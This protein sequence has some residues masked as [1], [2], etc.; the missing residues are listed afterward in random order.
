M[1]KCIFCKIVKGEIP[2]YKVYED[3]LVLAFLDITPANDGH[4]LIIPKLHRENIF[5]IK[6]EELERVALV[7]KRVAEKCKEA[8]GE[9]ECNIIHSTGKSAGQ[10]VMHFHMHVVPRKESDGMNIWSGKNPKKPDFDKIARKL[11]IN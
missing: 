3:E 7:A 4:T 9:G 2:S 10:E 5:D 1:E 6:K 11:K 8:L